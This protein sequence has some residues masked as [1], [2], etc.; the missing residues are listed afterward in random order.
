MLDNG[1]MPPKEAASAGR[2]RTNFDCEG[3]V[4]GLPRDR[5][6]PSSRRP[7][8]VVLRRLNNAE[9]TYTLRDLTGASKRSN[10]AGSSPAMRAAGEGFTNTGNAAVMS[11]SLVTKYLDAAK[12]L[13]AMRSCCSM[14]SFLHP[15]RRLA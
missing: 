1:E 5:K 11:P 13:P 2:R 9:Y 6:D 8:R 15:G 14:A 12:G 4:W 10:L 3:G 7:R